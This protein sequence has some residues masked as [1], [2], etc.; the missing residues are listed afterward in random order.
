MKLIKIPQINL[1]LLL[2]LTTKISKLNGLIIKFMICEFYLL[3]YFQFTRVPVIIVIELYPLVQILM[4]KLN[5]IHRLEVS[6]LDHFLGV[7]E[8]YLEVVIKSYIYI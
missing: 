7:G 2:L 8:K 5:Y 4:Y 6:G 1:L 3:I